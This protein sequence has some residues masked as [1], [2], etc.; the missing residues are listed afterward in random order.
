MSVAIIGVLAVMVYATLLVIIVLILLPIRHGIYRSRAARVGSGAGV[1]G[2]E[3]RQGLSIS[4]AGERC[5][6]HATI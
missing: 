4:P 3:S 2:A 1:G 5:V 6:W